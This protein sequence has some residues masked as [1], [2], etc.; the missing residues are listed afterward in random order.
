MGMRSKF[1]TTTVV[2]FIL[3][4]DGSTTSLVGSIIAAPLIVRTSTYYKYRQRILK[5]TL[6]NVYIYTIISIAYILSAMNSHTFS[7]SD[8]HPFAYVTARQVSLIYAALFTL[9]P[10][11]I[12]CRNIS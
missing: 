7:R 5:I 10:T 3:F 12:Y 8:F 6:E 2:F 11:E 4:I 9:I 1:E